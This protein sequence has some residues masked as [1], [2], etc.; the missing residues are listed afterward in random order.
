M[1][2]PSSFNLSIFSLE[3][4]RLDVKP[5]KKSLKSLLASSIS[6]PI[7]IDDY[8]FGLLSIARE[9]PF[10]REEIK[11]FATVLNYLAIAFNKVILTEDLNSSLK[12]TKEELI[13]SERMA[14]V[15]KITEKIAHDLRNPLSIV[16]LSTML[17]KKS[18]RDDK[19]LELLNK[20][21]KAGFIME[22]LVE[23]IGSFA[24]EIEIKKENISIAKIIED[25]LFLLEDKLFDIERKIDIA[26]DEP[27]PAD[28]KRLSEVFTNIIQN[29]IQSMDGK[30]VLEIKVEKERD[31]VRIDISD[32]G[33]G[34][35][36]EIKDKIFDSFF[37][38]KI[39]GL[40][41]GLSI[42]K[43]IIEKHSGKIELES[44]LGKGSCFKIYLPI[45]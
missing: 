37:T 20:V 3:I 42:V 28:H 21:E 14:A 8:E 45:K 11:L 32:T 40:G 2:I 6:L 9:S 16:L 18:T 27:I 44:S 4:A 34:I 36:P 22:K 38:T 7:I 33:R 17:A 23:G 25:S 26:Y 39:K 43:E 31:F 15:G 13:H 12:K 30:G 29:A 41:L 1:F 5:S 24:K 19:V 10:L 35:A